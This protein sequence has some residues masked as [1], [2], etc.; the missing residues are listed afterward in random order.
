MQQAGYDAADYPLI[1]L[2]D[3]ANEEYLGNQ[4]AHAEILVDRRSVRLQIR[5]SDKKFH[6]AAI[7]RRSIGALAQLYTLPSVHEIIET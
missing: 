4:Q 1:S 7:K 2:A 5:E 3:P 6:F